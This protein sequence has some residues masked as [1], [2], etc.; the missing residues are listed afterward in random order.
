V[1]S[2]Y[3]NLDFRVPTREW[4][5]EFDVW[6]QGDAQSFATLLQEE[7][8]KDAK[9]KEATREKKRKRA[10]GATFAREGPSVK[11]KKTKGNS[12]SSA[13]SAKKRRVDPSQRHSKVKL[14]KK[15]ISVS[16]FKQA[17]RP[18]IVMHPRLFPMSYYAELKATGSSSLHGDA[19]VKEEIRSTQPPVVVIL[20]VPISRG[21]TTTRPTLRTPH[22][23]RS[24][25]FPSASY[26]PPTAPATRVRNSARFPTSC[27]QALSE[28]G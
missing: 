4:E 8:E 11:Q 16:P 2:V 17:R 25:L 10:E 20:Y 5:G 15:P 22:R 14:A 19:S 18:K 21:T 28:D 13:K 12:P 27:R 9:A 24:P 1:T 23:S 3:L 6:L 7:I 26:I